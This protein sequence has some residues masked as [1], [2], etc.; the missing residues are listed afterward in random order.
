MLGKAQ[1][2]EQTI[3]SHQKTL[4]DLEPLETWGP[5]TALLLSP[6]DALPPA[7][8]AELTPGA[9]WTWLT[10]V[11]CPRLREEHLGVRVLRGDLSGCSLRKE[12]VREPVGGMWLSQEA[13]REHGA[14]GAGPSPGLA[15][16]LGL[17]AWRGAR[18]SGWRAGRALQA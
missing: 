12:E 8:C 17:G 5:C 14:T 11:A 7:R 4:W 15:A 6:P 13:P 9:T 10:H 2:R 16:R 3:E 18:V 1:E